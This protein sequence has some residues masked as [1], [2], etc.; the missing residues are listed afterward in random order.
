[1]CRK[2]YL[3]SQDWEWLFIKL[4][5]AYYSFTWIRRTLREITSIIIERGFCEWVD[6][7]FMT[8]A[9]TQKIILF[10]TIAALTFFVFERWMKTATFSI[11]CIC[12][13]VYSAHESFGVQNRTGI[14]TLVWFSIFLAYAWKAKKPTFDLQKNRIFFPVQVIVAC[15]T[16]SAISKLYVSGFSWFLDSQNMVLQLLKSNQV[17]FLDGE[18]SAHEI[19]SEKMQFVMQH[20]QIMSALLLGALLIELTSG[21]ALLNKKMRLFYGFLLLCLHIGIDFFFGIVIISF[22]KTMI[23]FLF[24]PL[25]MIRLVVLKLFPS[26]E[27]TTE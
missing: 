23:V 10:L 4:P 21:L 17:R 3:L 27:K 16:L 13:V 6:C 18:I 14:V 20:P 12:F 24:N 11:A 25:E 2:Q 8:L 19:Y 1:V 15:Y 26:R 7:N 9:I 5:F 22:L